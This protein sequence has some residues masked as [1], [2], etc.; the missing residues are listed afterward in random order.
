LGIVLVT[1]CPEPGRR[2]VVLVNRTFYFYFIRA[3][4]N[5]VQHLTASKA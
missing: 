3:R 5:Q 2:V 4:H 1:A